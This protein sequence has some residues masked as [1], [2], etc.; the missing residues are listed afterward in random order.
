[1]AGVYGGAPFVTVVCGEFDPEENC[2]AIAFHD[3]FYAGLAVG[4]TGLNENY[5]LAGL[6]LEATEGVQL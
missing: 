1:M 5:F 6:G 4:V 2:A 3:F